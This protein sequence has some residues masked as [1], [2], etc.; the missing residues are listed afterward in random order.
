[1]RKT[2]SEF[3]LTLANKS[4]IKSFALVMIKPHAVEERLEIIIEKIFREKT[5]KY[6]R[7]MHLDEITIQNFRKIHPVKLFYRSL[8]KSKYRPIFEIFYKEDIGTKY[9]PA[10]IKEYSK[11]LACF[12][13]LISELETHQ[14]LKT[15]KEVK[16]W[17][18]IIDYDK[19]TIFRQGKGLRGILRTPVPKISM[20]NPSEEE[21]K[22][23][24]SNVIHTPDDDNQTIEASKILLN[25]KELKEI[26]SRF[27]KFLKFLNNPD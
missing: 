21:I 9:Y 7:Y 10:M 22:M 19:N 14:L 3:M 20:E 4:K 23:I 27:P 5:D 12:L 2:N 24:I 18:Q 1:M 13:L 26:G 15:L 16:G 25:N 17:E 11:G 6:T 8:L